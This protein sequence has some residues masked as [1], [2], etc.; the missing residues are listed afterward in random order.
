MDNYPD[1]VNQAEF[2]RAHDHMD[3]GDACHHGVGFDEYCEDCE[4]EMDAEEEA[5]WSDE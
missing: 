5:R 1:G 3:D 2:D 4:D